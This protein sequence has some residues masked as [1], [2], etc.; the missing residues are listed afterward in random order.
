MQYVKLCDYLTCKYLKVSYINLFTNGTF[1]LIVV[2]QEY[3]IIGEV[4]TTPYSFV[5]ITHAFWWNGIKPVFV[6]SS[7][8]HENL[9]VTAKLAGM[10]FCL[11]IYVDSPKKY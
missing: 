1:P 11:S 2:L 6:L 7:A 10:V 9:Q 3:E 4:I 8:K 5:A